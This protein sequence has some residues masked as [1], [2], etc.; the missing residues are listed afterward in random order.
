MLSYSASQQSPPSQGSRCSSS[1]GY[2]EPRPS[3]QPPLGDQLPSPKEIQKKLMEKVTHLGTA[4][5]V[6]ENQEPEE[7][8]EE[9]VEEKE[10]EVKISSSQSSHSLQSTGSTTSGTAKI[11]SFGS[12]IKQWV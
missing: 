6:T 5:E 7:E 3:T 2:L 1:M 4:N 9:E 8:M 10:E 12:K 11:F